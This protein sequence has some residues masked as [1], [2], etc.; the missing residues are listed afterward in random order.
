MPD[1]LQNDTSALREEATRP[2]PENRAA[3]CRQRATDLLDSIASRTKDALAERGIMFDIFLLIP[4]SGDAL[5]LF[6]TNVEPDPS[7]EE[8]E[9]ASEVVTETVREALGI[10]RARARQV[11]CAL[12]RPA[13]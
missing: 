7:D 4:Q 5:V 10:G 8:W 13:T 2:A 12:V 1:E 9:M 6:G 11:P 3:L